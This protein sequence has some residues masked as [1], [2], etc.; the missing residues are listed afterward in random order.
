MP[1]RRLHLIISNGQNRP[2]P[3]PCVELPPPQLTSLSPWSDDELQEKLRQ[4]VTLHRTMPLEAAVVG[5]VID[6]LLMDALERISN[7]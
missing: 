6:N 4:L 5:L 1:H 7:T 2:A 3:L